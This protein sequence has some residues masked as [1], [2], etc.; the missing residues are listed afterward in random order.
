MHQVAKYWS[1]SISTSIEYSSLVSFRIDWFDLLAVQ[2]TLKSLL[3]HHNSKAS[4]LRCSVFFMVQLSHLYMTPGKTIPLTIWTF[5]SKVMSLLFNSLSRL[6]I[7][8]LPRIK[9]LLISWLQSLS[10]VILEPRK[11]KSVIV[12]IFSPSICH[13]VMGTDTKI[14]VLSQLF[15]SPFHLHREAL[16]L[17]ISLLPLNMTEVLAL[18]DSFSL[19]SSRCCYFPEFYFSIATS[20]NN[21]VII[22]VAGFSVVTTII[23]LSTIRFITASH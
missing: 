7:A 14:L 22:Y 2:R 16:F 1:F 11:I 20:Y 9:H 8:F 19:P 4:I 15:H 18:F 17:L 5:V 6:I 23:L 21:L 3:Q 13:E 10:E 12:S